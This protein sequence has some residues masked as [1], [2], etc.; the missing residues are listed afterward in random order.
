MLQFIP[1]KN[2]YLFLFAFITIIS[3]QA[4]YAKDLNIE[5]GL[6]DSSIR[7]YISAN[8]D[9]SIYALN[10]HGEIEDT[11]MKKTSKDYTLIRFGTETNQKLVIAA[12]PNLTT[13]SNTILLSCEKEVPISDCIWT[14]KESKFANKSQQYRGLIIIKPNEKDFTVINKIK[15]EDYLKGVVPSEM[16]SSWHK[17]ALKAQSVAART[18]TISKLNRRR[19][20][21]YDLKPTVEDQVYLGVN[22]EKDSTNQA[23]KETEGLILVDKQSKP[24]EAYFYSQAG[25]ST[26]S[27]SDVWGIEHHNYLRPQIQVDNPSFW[28][29]NFSISELNSKLADL[30]FSTI[31]AMTILNTSPDGRAKDVLVSGT[32]D[33]SMKHIKLTGEELRHK[34]GLRSTFFDTKTYQENISFIGKGFGHGI[35][36]SQYGAKKLAEQG[37][38]FK[39]ILEFY[40]NG[41]NLTQL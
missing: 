2:N 30:K 16:P 15:L 3:S 4:S 20:L 10:T 9:Y 17:E 18:Y 22:H 41:S 14:V 28:Q 6:F 32:K 34:L 38:S 27:A 26:A 13:S 33:S 25:F 11:L 24:I 8:K 7:N 23:I 37:K 36:M 35:G 1:R 5:I 29:K 40:Y 31:K 19:N 12:A 21:G 39:Q